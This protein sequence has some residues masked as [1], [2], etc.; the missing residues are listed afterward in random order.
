ML[1]KQVFFEEG[2]AHDNFEIYDFDKYDLLGDHIILKLQETGEIVGTYRIMC[3]E[4]TQNFY[5]EN[6]FFIQNFLQESGIK[7]ELGRACIAKHCRNGA[8]IALIWK[9]LAKFATIVNAKYMFGCASLST[10]NSYLA[11]EVMR[12]LARKDHLDLRYKVQ[13][14]PK[15]R[16]GDVL[17]V[18]EILTPENIDSSIPPLLNSYINAGAKVLGGPAFDNDFQ[19]ADIFTALDL[20]S[21]PQKYRNRY[22]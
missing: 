22:F 12:E 19:C 20:Q 7:I 2:L 4:F 9:G 3:S 11:H 1:R 17:L 14:Q 13:V 18:P 15:Y 16:S 21:L 6:E 10:M 8:T 5:S